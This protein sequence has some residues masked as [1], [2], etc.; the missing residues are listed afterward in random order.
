M[1]ENHDHLSDHEYDGIREYD[2]PTPGWWHLIFFLTI[3][4]G[5]LYFAFWTFSPLAPTVEEQWAS[6][7]R[8]DLKREFAQMGEL[9][10]DEATIL[11][12]ASA[13]ELLGSARA[14]FAGTCVAC[15][16]K[17]GGGLVGPNLCDDSYKSVKVVTDIYDVITN[18]A[19]NG[20]MPAWKNF[21]QN[22]R[23]VLAAYVASMRG[24]KPA[25]PKAAEGEV[26]PPWP[27]ARA[28]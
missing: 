8:A 10:P 6:E 3:V 9:K 22:E 15:H 7:R 25:A 28:N 1:S 5:V 21:S 27:A 20:A 11:R 19:A 13:P 24:T 14:N 18:G 23:V 16:T 4:F 12:L 17:D 2:N 26:I